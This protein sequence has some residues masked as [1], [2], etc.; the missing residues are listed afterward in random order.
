MLLGEYERDSQILPD[1]HEQDSLPILRHIVI[2]GVHKLIR[3]IIAETIHCGKV[4]YD[5]FS[6]VTTIYILRGKQPLD[7][8]KN[9][10]FRHLFC[11][12]PQTLLVKHTTGIMNPAPVPSV[13]EGLTRESS[14]QNIAIRNFVLANIHN[15]P[16][17]YRAKIKRMDGLSI[18]IEVITP[19]NVETSFSKTKIQTTAT[20]EHRNHPRTVCSSSQNISKDGDG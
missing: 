1:T 8:L 12:N 14:R 19:D 16:T 15:I 10:H 17:I 18:S 6:Q 7:I 3:H 11:N 4:L 9:D 2:S 20:G 5:D 13:R